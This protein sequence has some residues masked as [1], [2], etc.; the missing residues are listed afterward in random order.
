[1][2]NEKFTYDG[3]QEGFYN[4]NLA[5]NYVQIQGVAFNS[6][7]SN[8]IKLKSPLP[9]E[10]VLKN[11]NSDSCNGIVIVD[12][13]NLN[14]IN[15]FYKITDLKSS[16]SQFQG[17]GNQ[18]LEGAKSVSYIKKSIPSIDKFYLSKDTMS[19]QT[20]N[21]CYNDMYLCVVNNKLQFM[22][23]YKI[24]I[25]KLTKATQF[26]ITDRPNK[27][28]AIQDAVSGKYITH[29][30][31]NNNYLSLS[32]QQ[33]ANDKNST[34]RMTSFNNSGFA[35][36]LFGFSDMYIKFN[37]TNDNNDK[38]NIKVGKIINKNQASLGIFNFGLN[39]EDKDITKE[40]EPTNNPSYESKPENDN[41]VSQEERL[42][43]FKN[44]NMNML[45]KQSA[46]LEDQNNKI[47]NLEFSH[48]SNIGDISREFAYQSARLAFSKYMNE[49]Q[50][51][52]DN[53]K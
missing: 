7:S 15:S 26:R 31:P 9:L 18:R 13:D 32:S 40:P 33:D 2:N 12:S 5:D 25:N 41:T 34:F 22:N 51:A 3:I 45:N 16:I 35:L 50:Q 37:D 6:N 11:C 24:Q 27:N 4:T 39:L 23:Q 10:D 49:T 30:F 1:M 44:K 17:S 21:I 29:N 20:F 47:K 36:K 46:I 38:N 28:I 8:L 42:N 43:M 48:F 19:G 53:K 52:I 14:E